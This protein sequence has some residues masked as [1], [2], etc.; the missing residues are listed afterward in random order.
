M[1]LYR[2]EVNWPCIGLDKYFGENS[3]EQSVIYTDRYSEASLAFFQYKSQY[4]AEDLFLENFPLLL[5]A[6][7]SVIIK[8]NDGFTSWDYAQTN[9]KVKSTLGYLALKTAC[10]KQAVSVG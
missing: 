3:G 8:A 5:A 4:W 7:S 6:G 10:F 1:E 9:K 2:E